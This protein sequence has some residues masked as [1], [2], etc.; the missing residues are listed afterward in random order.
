[1]GDAAPILAADGAELVYAS[2]KGDVTAL[3]ALDLDVHRGEVLSLLGASGCGKSTLLNLFAGFLTPTSGTIRYDGAP[4][5][6]VNPKL[7]MIFQSYALFPWKTV[8]GNVEFGPAKAQRFIEMVGLTGFEQKYPSQL[9]GGMRQ[10]VALCRA[11]ANEPDVLLCDEPFAALDAMTRQVMQQEL[12]RIAAEQAMTVVFV[13]HSIDEALI[14]SDRI[15]V[16]SARPGR[17]KELRDNPLPKPRDVSVQSSDAYREM[18]SSI[19]SVVEAE[20]LA[21][22]AESA[23][24]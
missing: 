23:A 16:M 10:R 20:V 11:L 24:K 14:I 6:G 15:A 4:V 1:M 8:L 19:W 12:L 3:Q 5:A 9:S 2:K 7:A 18:K 17:V 13:T 22:M 21:S